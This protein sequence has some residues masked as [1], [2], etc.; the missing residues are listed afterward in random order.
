[1]TP[2]PYILPGIDLPSQERI[3]AT[4]CRVYGIHPDQL[5]SK[6]RFR[7]YVEPRHIV[8][9]LIKQ[10]N[11]TTV[12]DVASLLNRDH[13]TVLYAIR[14]IAQLMNNNREFKHRLDLILRELLS[15]PDDR[16]RVIN[17]ITKKNETKTFYR[18]RG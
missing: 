11:N 2:N 5:R 7:D 4:V 17:Q 1:M 3:I 14:T 9:T 10:I 6:R 13:S 12:E 18:V 15:N 16:K 8:M